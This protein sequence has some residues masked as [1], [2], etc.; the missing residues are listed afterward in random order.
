[1]R[2]KQRQKKRRKHKLTVSS[3]YNIYP[4]ITGGQQRI[5]H[6][7][8]NLAHFFDINLITYSD[9]GT[10]GYSKYLASGFFEH[11]IPFSDSQCIKQE[12]L[13]Q[14]YGIQVYEY[15][16]MNLYILTYDYMIKLIES[17][18]NSEVTIVS[19]PYTFPAVKYAG[20]KR[21]WYDAHNV[22]FEVKRMTIEDTPEHHEVL[23]QVRQIE[24]ECCRASEL[25]LVC[26]EKDKNMICDLYKV[27]PDKIIVVPNGSD[28][29]NIRC[30]L[31]EKRN[32]FSLVKENDKCFTAFFIGA[33]YEPNFVAVENI[34]NMA[35]KLTDVIFVVAGDVCNYFMDKEVPDNVKMEGRIDDLTKFVFLSTCDIALNP[36]MQ[37]SGTNLKMLEYFSYGVPVITTPLGARGFDV[38]DGKHCMIREIEYFPEAILEFIS[39]SIDMKNNLA[40]NART[41]VENNFNWREIAR[42]AG[43]NMLKLLEK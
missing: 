14:D 11:S 28:V 31:P 2:L 37:G 8:K 6:L 25:I 22:E 7:Y 26:S 23:E 9:C 35:Q 33:Y 17:I 3:C 29:D 5:F 42:M 19:H 4:T 21:I 20:A 27:N 18:K 13:K 30:I 39:Y 12:E 24:E 1:M 40:K 41:Y 34:I 43:A 16:I 15:S 38:E 32:E 36:I 10:S